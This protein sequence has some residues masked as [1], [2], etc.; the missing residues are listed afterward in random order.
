MYKWQNMDTGELRGDTWDLIKY[1]TWFF[2]YGLRH[3][4][5][6]F[7]PGKWKYNKKGW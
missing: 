1:L 3:R 4:T 5:Q 7:Y 2:F 6:L